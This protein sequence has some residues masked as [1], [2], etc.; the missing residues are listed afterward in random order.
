MS[1]DASFSVPDDHGD[2][3][4]VGDY[5]WNY[6]HN[7]NRAIEAALGEPAEGTTE[8]WWS[9]IRKDKSQPAALGSRSWWDL[10]DGRS[11]AEGAEFL[12]N[13]VTEL[14][15]DPDRYE[16][17]GPH[18]GWG[19]LDSLLKVLDQMLAASR[20]FAAGRWSVSG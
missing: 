5:S 7:M 11:G 4:Y 8:P 18:N 13:L 14:R 17:L 20:S 6:T 15:R 1:W 12:G 2:P 10:L 19:D 9:R 3:I 16:A